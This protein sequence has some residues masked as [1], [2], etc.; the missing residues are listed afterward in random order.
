MNLTSLNQGDAPVKNWDGYHG[1]FKSKHT[2]KFDPDQF[3]KLEINK[4]HCYS[5]PL[6]CGGIS[7]FPNRSGETHKPEYETVTAFGSLILNENIDSIYEINELLN[8]AGMDSI[9]AGASIAYAFE[10]FEKGILT[11]EDT[12]GLNLTWGNYHIL[13]ELL[14]QMIHREKF[15]SLLTDGAKIAALK[16]GNPAL[17]SPIHAGGQELAMHDGRNDPGFAI[18]AVVEATPGRHTLGS[19]L[20]YEMFALWKKL[21][22]Y[23]N[24]KPFYHKDK[25]YKSSL[26]NVQMAVANSKFIALLNGTGTC[27]F[28]AF[29]GVHRFPIF[30]WLNAATGWQKSPE[31]YM[32]IGYNI[33]ELKQVF[34]QK[35]SES[36]IHLIT[37]RAIGLPPQKKGA[38]QNRS[39]NL[40]EFVPA[41]FKELGWDEK[42]GQP[43]DQISNQI[44]SLYDRSQEN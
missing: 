23:P 24:I 8:R 35:Q 39:V 29:L 21:K 38:N 1:N 44:L 34:N 27:L 3:R 13:P 37:P 41:Y 17:A 9:S 7:N 43:T 30:E 32:Q 28:G 33:H 31:E 2:L 19:N 4:Y 16:L 12:G 18:H 36:L 20:Y 10:C 40:K 26:E 11:L 15:G 25:K 5:C 22:N 6:G 42:T 14:H